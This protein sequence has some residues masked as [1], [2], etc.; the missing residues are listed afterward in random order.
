MK[1]M[2]QQTREAALIIMAIGILAMVIG[3][4]TGNAHADDNACTPKPAVKTNK[5]AT[6]IPRTTGTTWVIQNC[7]DNATVKEVT[8][9]VVVEV[10]APKKRNNISLLGVA[11]PTN[12]QVTNQGGGNY[13]YQ[14]SYQAD[15]GLMYQRD[16]SDS[17]RGSLGGTVRGTA[18]LGL[19]LNF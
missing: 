4:W 7:G 16:L 10:Q 19:G 3:A 11:N 8:K 17:I 2:K 12:L 5:K 15:A 13:S 1:S 18:F 6:H 14:N 9:T